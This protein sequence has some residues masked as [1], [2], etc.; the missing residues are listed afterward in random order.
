MLTSLHIQNF[1]AFRNLKLEGLGRVNLITGANNVGKTALLE[2]LAMLFG[3][4]SGIQQSLPR[5]FRFGGQADAE[6]SFWTW[7]L[8][9]G[10]KAG[11]ALF[12][13]CLA[14]RE[15]SCRV[16]IGEAPRFGQPEFSE[17]KLGHLGGRR[18]VAH[19]TYGVSLPKFAVFSTVPVDSTQHAINF[20]RVVIRRRRKTVEHLLNE[21]EPR[22]ITIEFL[23]ASVAGPSLY[24]DVGLAELLPVSQLGQGFNR[25]LDI[26]SELVAEDAKV[27]LI[28]EIENGLYWKALPI[29]WKGLFAAA[30]ELDVQIFATTHS[31]ECIRAADEAARAGGNYDLAVIRLDRVG[32]EIKPTVMGEETMRT[33]KEF[34]WEI[35]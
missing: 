34:G 9:G 12:D 13:G 6:D 30:R 35:R 31:L 15:V 21:L 2:S 19:V 27:L 4:G 20:N 18:S 5:M 11:N 14:G 3:I 16:G 17:F 26:Y 29:V 33:A 28:D 23:Q 7:L 10:V 25:L 22:L 32:D 1:R 8:P 24:A